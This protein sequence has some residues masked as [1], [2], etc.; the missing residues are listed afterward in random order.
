MIESLLTRPVHKVSDH[1]RFDGRVLFLTE[2]P[3]LIKRQLAGEDLPFDPHA[4]VGSAL[5]PKL[6]DNISTDEITP[7]YICYYFDETLGEFP[8]L[9]LKAGNEF[10]IKQGSVQERAASSRRSSGKRRGKGSIARAEPLRRDDGRRPRGHRREHRAHLPRELPE[11]G[12]VHLH[13]T[14]S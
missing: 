4:Q 7:A 6:R 10:P 9:G 14:S 3:E 8:Y 2:S 11:P 5:H 12:R 1:V 13:R